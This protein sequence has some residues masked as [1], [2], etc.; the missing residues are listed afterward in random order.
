MLLSALSVSI[1]FGGSE[2]RMRSILIRALLRCCN[3]PIG[4]PRGVDQVHMAQSPHTLD[5]KRYVG[6]K[7]SRDAS[8]TLVRHTLGSSLWRENRHLLYIHYFNGVVVP[9]Y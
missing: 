5:P 7:R 3:L 8:A 9:L 6:Q 2:H 4:P 1:L